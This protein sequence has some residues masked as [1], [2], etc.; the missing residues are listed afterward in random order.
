L[1]L[2][3]AE[4]GLA[5][6]PKSEELPRLRTRALNGLRTMFQ[7]MNPFK[8]IIYSEWAKADLPLAE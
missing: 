2:K 5:N 6:F 3:V 1:A 8:F 4:L 7:A